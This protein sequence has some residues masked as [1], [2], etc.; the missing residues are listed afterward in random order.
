LA[1]VA[2]L[3][4]FLALHTDHGRPRAH[5]DKPTAHGYRLE[6]RCSCGVTFRRWV[7]PFDAIGDVLPKY[8]LG[9]LFR[10]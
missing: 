10:I 3:E 4:I 7:T 5:A 9:P 2:D 6:V 8:V 1:V